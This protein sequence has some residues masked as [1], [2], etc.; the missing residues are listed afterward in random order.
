[1]KR[2]RNR[3]NKEKAARRTWLSFPPYGGGAPQWS[4]A[5]MDRGPLAEHSSRHVLQPCVASLV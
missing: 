4:S 2:G 3:W 1:V 5:S